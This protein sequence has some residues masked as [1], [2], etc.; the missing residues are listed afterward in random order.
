MSRRRRKKEAASR[1]PR[2][3]RSATRAVSLTIE[4]LEI[5]R[6]F[7]GLLRGAPEPVL[8]VG[9]YEVRPNLEICVLGRR[10]LRFSVDEK[11][12]GSFVPRREPG[13]REKY[14]HRLTEGHVVAIVVLAIEED[15]GTGLAL[16]HAALEAPDALT[17]WEADS[18][19]PN[20]RELPSLF[21]E[22][23]GRDEGPSLAPA[24]VLVGGLDVGKS[25]EGD[26]YVGAAVGSALVSANA[27]AT[28]GARFLTP[29][30]RNDWKV[31]L[32]FSSGALGAA[33]R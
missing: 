18:A 13:S 25:C 23:K 11:I 3:A 33:L 10:V 8:L 19:I 22:A 5:S 6:G 20:V 9:L 4:A 17:F 14:V 29:D 30:G 12:P 31:R 7:D 21:A 24:H 16:L 1:A 32:T 26:D 15:A 28:F 2:P 27:H